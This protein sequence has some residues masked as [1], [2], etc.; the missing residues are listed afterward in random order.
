MRMTLAD[1][2]KQYRESHDL[3]QRQFAALCGVSNGYISMLEKGE[4]PKTGEPITPT[5]Q[6]VIS[7]ARGM[8]MTMQELLSEVDDLYLDLTENEKQPPAV[9]GLSDL[10]MQIARIVDRL[11]EESRQLLLVEVQALA[12]AAQAPAAGEEFP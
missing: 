2:L 6:S 3:S 8:G 7:I 12:R 11:P 5:L 9:E 10:A 4:N 1:Y